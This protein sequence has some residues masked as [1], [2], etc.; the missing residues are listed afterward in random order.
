MTKPDDGVQDASRNDH[1]QADDHVASDLLIRAIDDELSTTEA[2]GV[3]SH[4]AK[5]EECRRMQQDLRLASQNI[6]AMIAG[7]APVYL[8]SDRERL[9]ERL[10][11]REHSRLP[12]ASRALARSF[13][14]GMA[15]AATLA[16]GVL[17]LPQ[18]A[19]SVKPGHAN[20]SEAQTAIEVDGESFVAL[21]YSNPELPMSSSHIVQ[22]QIPVSS[23]ADAG[24]MFE[25]I[26]NEALRPDESVLADV[27]LGIDGQPLGVHVLGNQ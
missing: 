27:L 13:G 16:I 4:L 6:D 14:W 21:P 17:L 1:A 18:R 3:E 24:I 2:L 22:M 11:R 15:I 9:V 5:C 26:A 20:S 10:D 7:V 12:G 25:P 8:Q 19:N 23:L